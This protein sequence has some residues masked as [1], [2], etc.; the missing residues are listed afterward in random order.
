MNIE[1]AKRVL[2][3][4]QEQQKNM[5]ISAAFPSKYLKAADLSGQ[6]TTA[7]MTLVKTEQVARTGD[8]QPVLYLKEFQ[9]GLVLNKT[10]G[11]AI[12]KLF[13]DDT[14]HWRGKKIEIFEAMVEFQGDVMPALR[15]R[16]AKV[17]EPDPWE[18][19]APPACLAD[20]ER[21]SRQGMDAFSAWHDALSKED[22]ATVQPFLARLRAS[23]LYADSSTHSVNKPGLTEEALKKVRK[24][25]EG[26]P[27]V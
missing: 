20:G 3:H 7:T 19:A 22:F 24:P 11:K 9:Q 18:A 10:N 25:K 6:A 2:R 21:A 14:A 16:A 23:A 1:H 13:G 27:D 5:L 12:A 15:V 26:Q 4:Q 17:A 8:P